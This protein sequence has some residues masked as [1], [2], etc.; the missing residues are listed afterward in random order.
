M[1]ERAAGGNLSPEAETAYAKAL[2]FRDRGTGWWERTI[3][4]KQR[5]TARPL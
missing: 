5:R 2:Y 4:I 1:E 3:R